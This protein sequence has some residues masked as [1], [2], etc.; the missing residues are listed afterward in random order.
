MPKEKMFFIYVKTMIHVTVR[1]AVLRQKKN[2]GT[3]DLQVTH[4]ANVIT[5]V[6]KVNVRLVHN[7]CKTEVRCLWA[8]HVASANSSLN[9]TPTTRTSMSVGLTLHSQSL[10]YSFLAL[11]SAT[12]ATTGKTRSTRTITKHVRPVVTEALTMIILFC[13]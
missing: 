12:G 5:P 2:V 3:I 1:A 11:R 13:R 9:L 8:S 4:D 7:N 10:Q 6:R